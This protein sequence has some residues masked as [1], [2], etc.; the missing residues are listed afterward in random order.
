MSGE[1]VLVMKQIVNG[2][3]ALVA[4]CGRID[5]HA[6]VTAPKLDGIGV[7]IVDFRGVKA[8][9]SMGLHARTAVIKALAADLRV[10]FQHCPLRIV[11]QMNLFPGFMGGR[12]VKVLSFYAPYYCK[13]CDRAETVYIETQTLKKAAGGAPQVPSQACPSCK[14][15]M[16]FGAIE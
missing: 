15:T 4:L 5:A 1:D 16:E 7:L 10:A 9:N 13:A 3:R 8:I 2:E 12:A 14:K 6:K 11:N